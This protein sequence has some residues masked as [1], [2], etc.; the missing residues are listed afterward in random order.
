MRRARVQREYRKRGGKGRGGEREGSR[1]RQE[2]KFGHFLG[3]G[4]EGPE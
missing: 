1:K 3:K 4:L 2:E